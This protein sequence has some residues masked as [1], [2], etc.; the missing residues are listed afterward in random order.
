MAIDPAP[1][2]VFDFDSFTDISIPVE[3]VNL[4]EPGTVPRTIQAGEIAKAIPKASYATIDHASHYSMFAECKPG[5][6]EIAEKE[7]IGDPICSDG[8]EGN[9]GEIHRQMIEMVINA[10]DRSLKPER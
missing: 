10:F 2:D 9:R 8:A 4:G 5:A 6:A 3:L 1:A 7:D